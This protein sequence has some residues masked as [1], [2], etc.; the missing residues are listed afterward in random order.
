MKTKL[1]H[2]LALL[3][4][5]ENLFVLYVHMSC[6]VRSRLTTAEP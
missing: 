5:E 6:T 1:P 3:V 4:L 2:P